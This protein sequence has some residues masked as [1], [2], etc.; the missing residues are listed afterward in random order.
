MTIATATDLAL[1]RRVCEYSGQPQRDGPSW[2]LV[3]EHGDGPPW[4]SERTD[5][6]HKACLGHTAYGHEAL[7]EP[8]ASN[9]E[10]AFRETLRRD[11]WCVM[12]TL[13]HDGALVTI[14]RADPD[15]I[16]SARHKIPLLAIAEA[17]DRAGAL[18]KEA[19]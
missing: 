4:A 7:D 10:V 19:P 17:A 8:Y 12:L 2:R 3:D 13:W 14:D 18:P 15:T 16:A 1:L 11:K 9:L 6:V 5:L